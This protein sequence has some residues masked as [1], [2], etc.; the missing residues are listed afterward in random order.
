MQSEENQIR[1]RREALKNYGKASRHNVISRRDN[2]VLSPDQPPMIH[3]VVE[4]EDV[5]N[6]NHPLLSSKSPSKMSS[7]SF[8][9]EFQ[10]DAIFDYVKTGV[11]SIIE[12]E[13]T[14]RFV[15]ED[16]KV[17]T[18]KRHI[19]TII[20]ILKAISSTSTNFSSS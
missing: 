1:N 18:I 8:Q 15:A 13:V 10:L 7:S 11:G 20:W 4:E 5:D 14:Q 12:D 17:S 19:T 6:T 9:H 3:E 2:L 16:L